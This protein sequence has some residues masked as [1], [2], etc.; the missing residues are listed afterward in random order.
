MATTG[1]SASVDTNDILIG[2]S[3][4]S[5]WGTTAAEA[6]QLIRLDSEGFSGSKSR[7]RPNEIDPSGQ[8]SHAITT[9]EES[10]GLLNFSVSAGLATNKLLAGS[11]R[12]VWT[13]PVAMSVAT[14]A[15]SAA[16][17]GTRTCSIT[18][19]GSGFT[20]AGIVIGQF[21][22]V[23]GSGTATATCSFIGR[24]L[25]VA[26]GTLTFDCVSNPAMAT[27]LAAACGTVTVKGSMLRNGI[28]KQSYTFE[29]TL[30]AAMFLNYTGCM[31]TGGSLDVSEGDYLKGTLAFLN[32]RE[33]SATATVGTG[34]NTAAPTAT[35]IDSVNGIGDVWR[36][37][38]TGSTPGVPAVLGGTTKK[39]GIKWNQEGAAAQNGIGSA[40]ALG[41]RTGKVLGTGSL[42]T[43][44]LNFTLYSQYTNEQEGPISFFAIDG[45]DLAS[46]TKGYVI[47]I[48]NATIM[49]PKIVAGGPGQDVMADFEIEANPDITSTQIFGG[50]SLQIDFFN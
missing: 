21:L 35:V 45:N 23:Y 42:S 3:E 2:F 38:N 5:V 24:V 15:V 31:A 49:N 25:T 1:T 9:K 41:V 7:T 28:T 48:C 22:K 36:G 8:A 6:L 4:E 16:D 44:F 19:S 32:K 50:K 13:T 17:N 46:A 20:A 43:Y 18:D 33:L 39:L 37:I 40:S 12:G 30:A 10:T 29:K 26:D 14:I 34:A 27:A 47:T 11:L